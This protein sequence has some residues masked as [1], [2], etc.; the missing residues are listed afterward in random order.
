MQITYTLFQSESPS[1]DRLTSLGAYLLICSIFVFFT[2]VE[3]ALVLVLKE[4]EDQIANATSIAK[5]DSN[6]GGFI[7][8]RMTEVQSTV[9]KISPIE[10]TNQ[11]LTTVGE[12]V[13]QRA[14]LRIN[15]PKFFARLTVTRKIDFSTF[16]LYHLA[17]LIFNFIY[18]LQL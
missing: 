14:I 16:V 3:F 2:M 11:D 12:N 6:S 7:S 8:R 10:T 15:R 17:F 9:T 13:Q 5:E 18:W 1:G 4:V